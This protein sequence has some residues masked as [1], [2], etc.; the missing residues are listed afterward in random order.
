[1]GASGMGIL[2]GVSGIGAIVGSVVLASLP[3][4]KRGILLLLS[5]LVLGIS[6]AAFSFSTSWYLSLAFIIF[7]GIGQTGR[8]T[9][10][11]TLLQYY[12][13]NEYRGRVMSIYMMEFGLTS[14]GT[15]AAALLAEG[16]GVQWGVGGFALVLIF[17]SA[18]ALIFLPRIRRLD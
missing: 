1:V 7:V 17:L 14:F 15:F 5:G 6:L 3:N 10:S 13:E 4:K 8:M 18:L 2:I 12:V 16:F 9:L 11:N